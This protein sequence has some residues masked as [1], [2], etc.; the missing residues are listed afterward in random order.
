MKDYP[1]PLHIEDKEAFDNLVSKYYPGHT[2]YNSEGFSK[3]M[4]AMQQELLRHHMPRMDEET[5]ARAERT[6]KW[7]KR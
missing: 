3:R 1:T 6:L 4:C 5:A 7:L 2:H